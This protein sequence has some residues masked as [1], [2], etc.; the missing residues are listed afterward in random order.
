MRLT[1][2]LFALLAVSGLSI[3]AVP[4]TCANPCGLQGSALG[5]VTPVAIVT[6]GSTVS[7]TALD[8]THVNA[9]GS[10]IQVT[11]TCFRVTYSNTAASTPV[12]LTIV[13]SELQATYDVGGVPTTSTCA[14]AKALP[15]GSFALPYY[16]KLHPEMHGL[17]V[18][19]P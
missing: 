16:C 14:T 18:V 5:F 13:G 15:D 9:D 2:P 11:D 7:W 1:L 10:G 3:A 19:E 8:I 17:I 6:S 4:A 12:T